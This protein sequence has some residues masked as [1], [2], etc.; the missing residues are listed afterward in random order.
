[1]IVSSL[2][3]RRRRLPWMRLCASRAVARLDVS[4]FLA[5]RR[6]SVRV[7]MGEEGTV[8][9]PR[10]AQVYFARPHARERADDAIG[11]IGEP[12]ERGREAPARAAERLAGNP[13][14][15]LGADDQRRP[16]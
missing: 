4:I 8:A 11:R 1:M 14:E 7:A 10:P 5:A 13:Q 9:L 3:D 2:C 12:D 6:I 15:H 16:A